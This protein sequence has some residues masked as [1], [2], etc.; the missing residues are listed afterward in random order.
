MLL[1]KLEEKNA[2]LIVTVLAVVIAAL[3]ALMNWVL[4]K[5]ESIPNFTQLQPALHAILNGTVAIL[6]AFGLFFIKNGKT[7]AHKKSMFLSFVLSTIFLLSYVVYHSLAPETRYGGDGFLKIFYLILLA[8]HI[9]ISALIMPFILMSFYYAW[10][11]K[12]EKHKKLAKK[13]WPFWFYVAVTGVIIYFMI[14]PY[15]PWNLI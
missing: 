15:Y 6:L 1:N 2:K 10:T 7:E 13:V 8:T 9:I 11:N 14:A 12:L 5:P 4:P 3:V